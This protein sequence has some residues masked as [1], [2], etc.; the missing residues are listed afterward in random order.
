MLH[1]TDLEIHQRE[2][3]GIVILDLRGKLEMGSGDITLREFVESLFAQGNRQL[4]LDLAK[5]SD[6]DT[7]GLGV[8]LLLAQQYRAGGGRLVLFQV[9]HAH[10]KIYE[11]ARLETVIEIYPDEIDAINSFF[12]DRAPPHYDILQ[13]V[14]HQS[15]NE[16]QSHKK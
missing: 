9:A 2:N 7:A 3:Q 16:D 5:V 8:L 10:A 12:P 1:H 14:E 13:Y 6:I 4:I 11:M 15:S